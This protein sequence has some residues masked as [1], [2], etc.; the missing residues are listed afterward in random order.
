MSRREMSVSRGQ[1]PFPL[2]CIGVVDR[3]L[4]CRPHVLHLTTVERVVDD[5]T[6]FI[7]HGHC[8]EKFVC[9][10]SKEKSAAMA[11]SLE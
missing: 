9:G 11:T 6:L 4:R 3:N 10:L 7:T 2:Q 8:E 1:C 5:C